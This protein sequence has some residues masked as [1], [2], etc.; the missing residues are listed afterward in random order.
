MANPLPNPASDTAP[1]RLLL[2]GCGDP[3]S[4]ALDQMLRLAGFRVV[5]AASVEAAKRWS[6]GEPFDVAVVDLDGAPLASVASLQSLGTAHQVP[7]IV[8]IESES[9]PGDG[10]A[11]LKLGAAAVLRAPWTVDE[12]R[13][14]LERAARSARDRRELA[15]L[16]VYVPQAALDA[17]VGRSAAAQ[18]LREQLVLAAQSDRPVL[19]TGDSG[20]GKHLAARTIHALSRRAAG[21]VITVDCATTSSELLERLLFGQETDRQTVWEI[22]R[23]GTV[24]LDEVGAMTPALQR[25]LADVLRTRALEDSVR[26]GVVVNAR[27][28]ATQRSGASGTATTECITDELHRHWRRGAIHVPSLHE[29]RSDIPLMAAA[30]RER[31]GPQL[32]VHLPEL[33]RDEVLRLMGEEWPGNV[34]QL[35]H[36]VI[37]LLTTRATTP[38]PASQSPLTAALGSGWTIERLERAYIEQ[39]L[40]TV[41]GNQSRAAEVLG[42][43]RRTLYRKLREYREAV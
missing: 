30:I 28:I 3:C 25:R 42:I 10:L 32:G 20:S 39:V 19:L 14:V 24:V 38:A 29:R 18:Q 40:D 23:E 33:A 11:A 36:A 1:T 35:E 22:A 26:P 21:Q 7:E 31:L 9:R 13:L 41:D 37:R 43:D 27:V 16:R 12:L 6:D 4:E 15:A 8:V 2:L 17:V 34:R 5:A